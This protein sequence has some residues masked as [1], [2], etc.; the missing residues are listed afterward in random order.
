MF[1]GWIA[2]EGLLVPDTGADPLAVFSPATRKTVCHAVV[3]DL[4]ASPARL[5]AA[6]ATEPQLAWCLACLGH[7]L[8]LPLAPSPGDLAAVAAAA[9]SS[10]SAKEA[11]QQV[12]QRS[13]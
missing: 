6:T 4:A 5:Q 10:N 13:C 9:G 3:N 1:L 7:A 2:R 12:Q 8:T 11:A